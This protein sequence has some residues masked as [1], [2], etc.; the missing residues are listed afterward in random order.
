MR[1]FIQINLFDYVEACVSLKYI[2][3]GGYSLLKIKVFSDF[4]DFKKR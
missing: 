1:I 3:N 2:G 4:A